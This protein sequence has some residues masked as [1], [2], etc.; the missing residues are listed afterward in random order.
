MHVLLMIFGDG[1][2]IGYA[3]S[4]DV[5]TFLHVQNTTFQLVPCTQQRLVD[6][7]LL[8]NLCS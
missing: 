5:A 2:V 4:D 1:V 3:V 6:H 8:L 7:Q